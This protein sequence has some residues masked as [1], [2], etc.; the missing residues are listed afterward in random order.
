MFIF[1]GKVQSVLAPCVLSFGVREEFLAP[2]FF[3]R[4]LS[5]ASWGPRIVL[6]FSMSALFLMG[7]G[8]CR[9]CFSQE[10]GSH[11]RARSSSRDSRDFSWEAAPTGGPLSLRHWDGLDYFLSGRTFFSSCSTFPCSLKWGNHSK[12][13]SSRENKKYRLLG[14]LIVPALVSVW[15]RTSPSRG[16]GTLLQT[17]IDL[18]VH[19]ASSNSLWESD[20]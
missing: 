16:N 8:G 1:L 14:S 5:Y 12:Q 2:H 7:A 13:T 6:V 4:Y 9:G 10:V 17:L 18:C 20:L 19:S 3:R 11:A 15:I